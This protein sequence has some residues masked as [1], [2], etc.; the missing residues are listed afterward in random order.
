MVNI[1]HVGSSKVVLIAGGGRVYT[2]IAARFVNSERSLE[3]IISS[4]YSSKIVKNILDSG[5]LAATEMDF[6]IFG[7]SGLSRVA[8]VQLVRKR[9]A[10]FLIKSGRAELNGKRQFNVAIPRNIADHEISYEKDGISAKINAKILLDMTEMFYSEGVAK[11]LP[12]ED[13]RYMK[14][15]ATTFTGV[16][17]MNAHALLDWFKIRTCFCAQY[18]IRDFANKVMAICKEVSPDLFEHAG[19]SCVSL[20]YCPENKRQH[21][22]CKAKGIITKDK[23]F[24]IMK[25][26]KTSLESISKNDDKYI[27]NISQNMEDTSL[28]PQC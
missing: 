8:E 3:E 21:K 7:V 26:H 16:F 13:L 2:D 22:S 28:I 5:H 9:C 4:P 17:A 12:E 23:A 24:E 14:Q 27:L 18:E 19:P 10:S 25:A 15:Q 1:E 6:F 11:G 20:G